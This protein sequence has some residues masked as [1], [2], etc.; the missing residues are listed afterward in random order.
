MIK[1]PPTFAVCCFE[2][3]RWLVVVPSDW[4]LAAGRT[5]ERVEVRAGDC[6]AIGISSDKDAQTRIFKKAPTI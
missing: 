4:S 2:G 3:D 5:F 1:L 6:G